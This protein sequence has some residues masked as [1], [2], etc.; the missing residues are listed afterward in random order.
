MIVWLPVI[1]SGSVDPR[2]DDSR[3]GAYG[4]GERCFVPYGAMLNE[5]L[6]RVPRPTPM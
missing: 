3:S 6:R 1:L 2:G 4:R 5:P